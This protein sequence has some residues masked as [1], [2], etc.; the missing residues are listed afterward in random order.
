MPSRLSRSLPHLISPTFLCQPVPHCHPSSARPALLPVP[1]FRVPYHNT[2]CGKPRITLLWGGSRRA[3][4]LEKRHAGR[5][6]PSRAHCQES[7]A[8]QTPVCVDAERM[9]AC[10]LSGLG[11]MYGMHT[12]DSASSHPTAPA[13]TSAPSHPTA[14][15]L[16]SAPSSHSP[17]SHFCAL[18]SHCPCSHFC[19]LTSHC[20]CSAFR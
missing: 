8:N 5:T 6:L 15:A 12:L 13:L 14:P 7:Q 18:T 3:S 9:L 1:P 20:P 2:R 4:S 16:T 19:A 10:R 17:C 11:C